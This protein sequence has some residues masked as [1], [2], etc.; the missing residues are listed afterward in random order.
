MNNKYNFKNLLEDEVIIDFDKNKSVFFNKIEIPM[1]QRDYAQ[2]RGK[3]EEKQFKL[4]ETGKRF[5][6]SI[7][8]ALSQM[9]DMEMDFVYGSISEY[10]NNETKNKEYTF[11]PLDGQQRLTTLFLLYWYIGSQELTGDNF[12]DLMSM[13]KKFTYSTR[14]SSRRFCELLCE[15]KLSFG[16]QP[17][18]E[19]CNLFWFFNS[20]KKDPTI[21]AMLNMLD[22]IHNKYILIDNASLY[23]NLDRLKFYILPLDGFNLTEDLYIKMNARGKQLT[24]FENFKADLIKW[25]EDDSNPE[26][27]AFQNEVEYHNRKMPYYMYIS[28]KMD[29][30]W[31]NIF[32]QITKNKEDKLVDPL[33]IRFFYRFLLNRFII[34]SKIDSRSLEKEGDFKFFSNETTYQ[35]FNV[36]KK[37]LNFSE[38]EIIKKIFDSLSASWVHINNSINP[39]WF[40]NDEKY[41]F[42]EN[43]IT[44]IQR[45]IMHGITIYFEKND[46]DSTKFKQWMRIVWNIVENTDISDYSSATGVMK[47]LSELS[48]NSSNIYQHLSNP[49]TVITSTSSKNAIDE[50]K[51]KSSFI[52]S[53]NQFNIDWENAFINAEKHRFFKGSVS[54]L[55]SDNVQISDFIHR[56]QLAEKVFDE[57]G[58]NEIYRK[59]GHIFLRALIS[60]YNESNQIIWKNFTDTDESEHYLKKMLASD[61]VVRNATREWFSLSDETNLNNKLIDEVKKPSQITGWDTNNSDT[62][63][64]TIKV[65]ENLYKNEDLQNWIQQQ[66]AIRLGWRDDKLYISRPSAWYDWILLDGYR[67]EIISK[68]LKVPFSCSTKNQCSF[69]DNKIDYYW[70]NGDVSLIRKVIISNEAYEFDY[71]FDSQFVKIGMKETEELKT[72]FSEIQ[73]IEP[74]DNEDGEKA[75]GWICRKKYNY[76]TLVKKETDI[77]T[78]II[79]IENEVFDNLNGMASKLKNEN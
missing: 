52:Y 54:F 11:I 47:L 18:E 77:D 73:F 5:L 64:R 9:N 69:S 62:Q 71:Q 55:I 76:H 39:S 27:Q 14:T 29:N 78:F 61:E 43:S 46:F 56:V 49:Q 58:V 57:K 66:K 13:L 8:E 20:Y 6:D 38:I 67:N 51:Y 12:S 26:S 7:F 1:I 15:T 65:H 33:F 2:G 37:N 36:F 21:K 28:Q 68:L 44:Q 48:D 30:E 42:L 53:N 45:V 34:L 74:T 25:M 75:N 10:N 70:G 41:S 35:N 32:W 60:C 72:R 16:K 24:A 17:S 19:L 40:K 79:Q 4:N 50:E 31:T 23:K 63:R 59:N 22:V 3:I